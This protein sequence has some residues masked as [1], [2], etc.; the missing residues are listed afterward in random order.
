MVI[1]LGFGV[2]MAGASLA[3][4]LFSKFNST[5]RRGARGA[6]GLEKARAK[7]ALDSMIGERDRQELSHPR[8]MGILKGSLAGRGLRRNK[9]QKGDIWKQETDFLKSSHNRERAAIEQQ[10]A[11]GGKSM[12]LLHNRNKLRRR[13]LP[14]EIWGDIQSAAGAGAEA[15]GAY[16]G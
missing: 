9:K 3:A 13:M 2:G 6:R 12:S 1:P 14:L 5:A 11:I 8:E 16:G 15:M 10:I 7:A 4:N